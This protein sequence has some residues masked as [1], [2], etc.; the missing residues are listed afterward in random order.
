MAARK[1]SHE[2]RARQAAAIHRWTPWVHSTGAQTTEGKAISS[3]NAFRFTQRKA[4][5]FACWVLNQR[6]K[7]D[8][9]IPY[10]SM[11]EVR[12]KEALRGFVVKQAGTQQTG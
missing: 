3:R 10:A 4:L 6:R 9:G 11:A 12:Q 8:A 2:Q 7:L 1:W 5:L